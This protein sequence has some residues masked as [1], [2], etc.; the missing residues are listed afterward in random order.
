[1]SPDRWQVVQRIF[2][3]V[4]AQEDSGRAAALARACAGDEALQREVESMLRASEESGDFL[5]AAIGE[6]AGRLAACQSR[7]VSGLIGPYEI[8]R[9]IGDGGM[10][11]VY[12]ARRADQ[13]FEKQVAIKLVRTGIESPELLRRFRTERQ[14][15][16]ALEHP[17]IARMLD[18]GATAD[19][20]PYVVM[21]YIDGEPI[22]QFLGTHPLSIHERLRIFLEVCTAVEYAHRNL[23]VHRDIKP[24][25][26]LVT[27]AGD[28]KLLDFGIAKLI[29]TESAE[30]TRAADRIMTPAFASP[31]QIRGE[32]V[33]T[34]TD[35]YSLGVL[36]Y[37]LIAGRNPFADD[38][39]DRMAR[40]I[41]EEDPEPLGPEAGDLA[42]IVSMA[43]RKEPEARYGSVGR[44]IDDIERYRAGFPVVAR[45]GTWSY[46]AAK[47]A[48]RHRAG[49][50]ASVACLAMLTA[51][52]ATLTVQAERLRRQRD[53]A[54][55][56]RQE[57]QQVSDYLAHLFSS[58]NPDRPNGGATTAGELLDSAAATLDRDLQGQPA[59]QMRLLD[60]MALAYES[61]GAYDKSEGL[62]R[63]E[64]V[65]RRAQG[66][67]LALAATLK[68]LSETLRWRYQFPEA[69]Q[70]ARESIAIRR[71]LLGPEHVDV[72][73]SVNT[74][75]MS[76]WQSGELAEAEVAFRE[77]LRIREKAQ[78]PNQLDAAVHMSN[79]AGVL[80]QRG[81]YAES[82]TLYRRVI[83][84][85]IQKLGEDHPRTATAMNGLGLALSS[86]AKFREAE[87]VLRRALELRS[88]M[89]GESHPEYLL[90]KA[91]LAEAIHKQGRYAEAEKLHREVLSRRLA[92]HGGAN[93]P[94]TAMS[95]DR[96]GV[97]MA[98]EGKFADAERLIRQSADIRRRAL[99]ERSLAAGQSLADLARV[100]KAR[101]KTEEAQETAR[102]AVDILREKLGASHPDTIAAE[103]VLSAAS[104]RP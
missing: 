11:A 92:E 5:E 55:L 65:F 9:K 71:R 66:D 64:L 10:G 63:R 17:H 88:R 33:T 72:A 76:L 84:I 93:H 69:E 104:P 36:L 21:E 78:G 91:D 4:E 94:R 18:G 16:A 45:K 97:L 51:F 87:T 15:L 34:A 99:G 12:L 46:T 79:L 80:R 26:I 73:D 3:E 14:I 13:Q 83:A 68:N 2:L 6:A 58:L 52:L 37:R 22:D 101:G 82:E 47:F 42:A 8:V 67:Q 77:A 57:A 27:P 74:L 7:A 25:N 44:L 48:R 20:L 53:A 60:I 102:L 98:D 38:S 40:R 1:V 19:G 81:N 85:R 24:G 23:I 59:V 61:M 31:E 100:L 39:P 90:T 95:L 70:L 50:I 35:V 32:P 103:K 86:Q 41:C 75:G 28:A 56:E 49:I 29:G 96:L 54:E 62:F 30:V 43:M 89:L